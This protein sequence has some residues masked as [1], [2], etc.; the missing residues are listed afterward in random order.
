MKIGDRIRVKERVVVYHHPQHRNQPFNL[1]GLEGEAID[2]LLD[3]Q[4]RAIS[5]NLPIKVKFERKFQAHLNHNEIE[6]LD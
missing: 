4:G 6:I 2:I 3:W 5:P 1:Q